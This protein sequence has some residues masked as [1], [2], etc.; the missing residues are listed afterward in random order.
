MQP[1]KQDL[2]PKGRSRLHIPGVSASKKLEDCASQEQAAGIGILVHLLHILLQ[3]LMRLRQV[4]KF[5][6]VGHWSILKACQSYLEPSEA[7]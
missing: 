2:D 3:D 5:A 4:S 1:H 6:S 7:N